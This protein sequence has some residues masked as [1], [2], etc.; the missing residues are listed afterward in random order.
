[1]FKNFTEKMCLSSF[2]KHSSAGTFLMEAGNE[3]HI[4]RAMQEK[5]VI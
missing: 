4:F 3:F 5:A 1:M 2:L